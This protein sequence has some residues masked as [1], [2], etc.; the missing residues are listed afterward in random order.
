MFRLK[1]RMTHGLEGNDPI[2]MEPRFLFTAP[3]KF[4]QQV[5]CC[6]AVGLAFSATAQQQFPVK[7]RGTSTTT[8]E[9]G[10]VVT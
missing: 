4:S 2:G 1:V 5:L 8:N 6:F 7:F 9:S 3:M 10:Q